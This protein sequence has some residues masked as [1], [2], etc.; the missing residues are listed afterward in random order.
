MAVFWQGASM[1]KKG[2]GLGKVYLHGHGDT[3]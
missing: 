1:V 3:S 2:L